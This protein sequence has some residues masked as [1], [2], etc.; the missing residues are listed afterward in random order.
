[1]DDATRRDFIQ[2]TAVLT[3]GIVAGG[4]SSVT[5]A[6]GQAPSTT[7]GS[8]AMS[9]TAKL[10]ALLRQPGIGIVPEAHSVFAARLAEINDFEAIYIGGNMMAAMYLGIEDWGLIN[11]TE[12]VEI[13]GR[14]ANGVSIPAIVDAD[15][16]GE[17]ALNVYRAVKAYEQAGIAAFHIEDTRNPKHRGRGRS[18][19]MPLDEMVLRIS[20]AVEGRSDPDFV[21]ICRSDCLGLG[22]NRG[23]TNEAIRRGVA[24]AEAGGDAFFC[25]GMR[26]DQVD[27]IARA[28]PIPLIALNIPLEDVRNTALKLDIHAV[29]VYQPVM[30]LYEEMIVELKEHGQFLRREERRPSPETMARVLQRAEYERLAEEWMKLRG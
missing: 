17:N 27:Q 15:Q 4:V 6:S 12:L 25:V 20:A 1:M 18:E 10:R 13:G 11:T 8:R 3:G 23:D 24:F 21:I 29:Q 28:I 22:Q 2:Q 14:I 9:K 16:G 19:L 30:K 7:S 5:A 26:S